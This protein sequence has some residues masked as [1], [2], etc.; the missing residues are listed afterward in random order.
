MCEAIRAHCYAIASQNQYFTIPSFAC[1]ILSLQ[2]LLSASENSLANKKTGDMK[3]GGILGSFTY[4]SL[5]IAAG[6]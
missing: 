4:L 1:I 2:E 3:K 5:H 6:Q